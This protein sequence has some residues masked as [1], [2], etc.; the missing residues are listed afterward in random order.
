MKDNLKQA[1][2]YSILGKKVLETT[3]KN[4]NTSK[5]NSGLYL[6]KIASE[7]GSVATKKF[8]KK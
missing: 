6:I 4:I 7:N 3:S 2:I 5:L 1:T 8:M